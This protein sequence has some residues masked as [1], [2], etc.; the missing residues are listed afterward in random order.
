MQIT[1][2]ILPPSEWSQTETQVSVCD[3]CRKAR[4]G[5]E[6]DDGSVVMLPFVT[7]CRW[8]FSSTDTHREVCIACR[9]P[10]WRVSRAVPDVNPFDSDD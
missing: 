6:Q 9:Q 5:P 10:G 7:D 2:Y 8:R 1:R 4:K 3:S